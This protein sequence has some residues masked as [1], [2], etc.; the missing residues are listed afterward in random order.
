MSQNLEVLTSQNPLGPTN[1]LFTWQKCKRS[2]HTHA[3]E[4]M[5][6]SWE[7]MNC[8]EEGTSFTPGVTQVK[9][10]NRC[11]GN[12]SKIHMQGWL[13]ISMSTT[14]KDIIPYLPLGFD[15][16]KASRKNPNWNDGHFRFT[17]VEH[18]L[19]FSSFWKQLILE[20]K[21]KSDWFQQKIGKSRHSNMNYHLNYPNARASI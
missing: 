7:V 16:C 10:N 13:P 21:K 6:Y 18:N 19:S 17:F 12:E 3:W 4:V 5:N 11:K 8:D 2:P 1:L 9:L 14:D 20:R 15:C